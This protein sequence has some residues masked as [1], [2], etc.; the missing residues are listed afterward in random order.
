MTNGLMTDG[1]IPSRVSVKPK[2]VPDSAMTRSD[3]AQQAH[4]AAERR[5]VDAGDDRHRAGVDGLE[6]VG[7]RH[8]VLLVALG[9][10]RHRGA[11][12][13]EVG[14]GTERRAVAGQDDRP[15]L[16]GRL[17]GER[18]EGRPQLAR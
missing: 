10:E 2:R 6:H 16:R 4:P 14:A 7:H 15:K 8:R 13:V 12:P 1:R 3:T 17:A 11:H 18:R 9:V 5:A